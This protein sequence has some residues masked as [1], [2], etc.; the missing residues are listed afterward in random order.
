MQTRLAAE[1]PRRAS[2]R[3]AL[4][5]PLLPCAAL[6]PPCCP[7]PPKALGPRRCVYK[8]SW[9]GAGVAVKY[10]VCPTDDSDSLGRAIREVRAG[11]QPQPALLLLC[12]TRRRLAAP[13]MPQSCRATAT[14]PCPA[15]RWCCPRR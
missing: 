5:S 3:T 8:G 9:R 6:P 11:A 10:I 1:H 15:C 14:L 4:G 2:V 13:V 7:P 12:A